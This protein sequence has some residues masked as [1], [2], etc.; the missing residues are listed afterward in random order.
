MQQQAVQGAAKKE[1]VWTTA[2]TKIDAFTKY[3]ADSKL[4][5]AQG[6]AQAIQGAANGLASSADA[7]T[8]AMGLPF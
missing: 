1:D 4:Q 7:A 2:D 8:K 6:R 5:Q 3:L